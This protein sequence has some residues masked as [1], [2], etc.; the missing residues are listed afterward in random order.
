MKGA[1]LHRIEQRRRAAHLEGAVFI[2]LRTTREQPASPLHHDV[3][4]NSAADSRAVAQSVPRLL[5]NELNRG[6]FFL[7]A[8]GCKACG[9]DHAVTPIS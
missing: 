2:G 1:T 9:M 5:R 6:R 7:V 4:R 3:T 8:S